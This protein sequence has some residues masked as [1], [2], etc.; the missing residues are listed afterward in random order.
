LCQARREKGSEIDFGIDRDLLAR[1]YMNKTQ[2]YGTLIVANL[3]AIYMFSLPLKT[4]NVGNHPQKL[5]LGRAMI[6]VG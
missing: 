5:A 2:F 6:C 1:Y 4:E 3:M